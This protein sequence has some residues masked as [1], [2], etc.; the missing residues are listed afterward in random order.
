M[1]SRTLLPVGLASIAFLVS[2][3]ASTTRLQIKRAPELS[4]PGVKTVKVKEFDVSGDLK[5][6]LTS[7]GGLLG[8]VVSAGLDAGVNAAA[9]KKDEGFQKQNLADLKQAILK[10]GY[11]K[12]TDGDNYDA[13]ISGSYV[14]DVEDDGEEGSEKTKEGT[15]YWYEIKR[16]A[17]VKVNFT[18][19]D[20]TGS[21]I[22]ASDASGATSASTQAD[23]RS[24]ARD[25]IEGWQSLVRKCFTQSNEALVRKI[26][27]YYVTESRSFEK[28]DDS[29]IKDAGKQASEGSWDAA[30]ATWKSTLS[31]SPKDKVASL[32]NLAIYDESQGEVDSALVK[33]QEVQKL[34]PSSSHARDVSRTLSRVEEIKRLKDAE[35]ARAAATPAPAPAAPVAAPAPAAPA[36]T[37]I[38]AAPAP[39]APA[40]ATKKAKKAN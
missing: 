7:G 27:P 2:G 9:S 16:K 10:N 34:D 21:V 40:K 23:N 3:C 35:A 36:S 15:R 5:L 20:K 14:Y 22:G 32:H 28:G 12:I 18:V 13:L 30:V 8:A 38:N 37:P 33:Y 4:L 17:S 29:R 31:G 6:D 19:A 11:Y 26:A 39:E 1:R 24:R 25:N